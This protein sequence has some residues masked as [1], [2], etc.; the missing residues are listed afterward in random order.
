MPAIGVLVMLSDIYDIYDTQINKTRLISSKF[1][2][3]SKIDSLPEN[4]V[5]S[6]F[7]DLRYL[8]R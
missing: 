2:T 4:V 8:S 1:D 6:S 5:G 7:S 3:A